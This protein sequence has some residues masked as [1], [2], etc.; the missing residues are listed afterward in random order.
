MSDAL[1]EYWLAN[2][3]DAPGRPRGAC[4]GHRVQ[5]AAPPELVWDFIADFQGWQGWN[6]LYTAT[7]GRAEVGQSVTFTVKLEG[8]KPQAGKAQVITIR[9]NELLEYRLS[10]FG[11]LLKAFRFVELDELS[12]TRCA[13]S[14][15]EIMAGPLGG[16]LTKAIGAKVGKGLEAMN[17]ALKA[18]AERK[19]MGRPG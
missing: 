9:P 4:V 19:W 2:G 5:I 16:L 11:G 8:V 14:N 10:K 6:P 12:P 17:L 15:G 13:V 7:G 3:S 1:A 18:M